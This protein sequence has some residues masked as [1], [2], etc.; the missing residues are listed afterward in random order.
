MNATNDSKYVDGHAVRKTVEG[1]ACGKCGRFF[2]G[3]RGVAEY[4]CATTRR[5]EKC[6]GP[7]SNKFYS[8]CRG[9]QD[10]RDATK[11]ALRKRAPWDGKCMIYSEEWD[12]W[13]ADPEMAV[14]DIPEGDTEAFESARFVLSKPD[15][16]RT[17]CMEEFLDGSTPEDGE[18]VGAGEINAI[19]NK[20]I[21]DHAPYSWWP[22]DVAWDG[23]TATPEAGE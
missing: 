18:I 1:W 21:A 2:G 4:C 5:C 20:W 10:V 8:L 6:G 22:S 14:D 12:R 15:N 11:H 17:F 7:C 3:D 23:T 16:G 19:V 13:F 9:C